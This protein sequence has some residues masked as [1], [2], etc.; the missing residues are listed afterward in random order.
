M[1]DGATGAVVSG[2]ADTCRFA[3]V[4]TSEV[5]VA[6]SVAVA[7]TDRTGRPMAAIALTF[8]S[9]DASDEHVDDL[10]THARAAA[11]DIAR[12]LGPTAPSPPAARS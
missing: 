12:R 8:R 4:P 1:F 10:V 7:V 2:A 5:L 9:R 11:A 6:A 3:P